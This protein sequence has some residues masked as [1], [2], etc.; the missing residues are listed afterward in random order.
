MPAL[1]EW[2]QGYT[3]EPNAIAVHL[4]YTLCYMIH[5]GKYQYLTLQKLTFSGSI[6][7]C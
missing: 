4:S 7:E 2:M 6:P 1:E 5:K 3:F